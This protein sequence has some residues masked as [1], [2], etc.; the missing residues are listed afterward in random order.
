MPIYRI[1][2]EIET[3]VHARDPDLAEQL[4]K[5]TAR[6]EVMDAPSVRVARVESWAPPMGFPAGWLPEDVTKEPA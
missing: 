6:L 2:Y 1:T 5:D 4:A 3:L